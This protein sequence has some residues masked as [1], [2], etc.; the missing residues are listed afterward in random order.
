MTSLYATKAAS[1]RTKVGAKGAAVTFTR[2]NPGTYDASTDGFT[3]ASDDTVAGAAIEM[4][5]SLEQYQALGLI[6]ADARTL[7]FTPDA[8]G[9]VPALD[10]V[11]I[12]GGVTYAVKSRAPFAPDGTAISVTVII[13]NAA[14]AS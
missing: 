8:F 3:G 6:A 2:A 7:F 12:W 11:V 9:Q 14:G 5:G 13:V 10:S 1:A 4:E